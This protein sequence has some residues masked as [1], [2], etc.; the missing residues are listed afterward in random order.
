MKTGSTTKAFQ[1][2]LTW[3]ITFQSHPYKQF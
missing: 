3:S 1:Q 2:T